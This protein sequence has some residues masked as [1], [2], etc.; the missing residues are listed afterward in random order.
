LNTLCSDIPKKLN[1]AIVYKN[2][3]ILR[4]FVGLWILE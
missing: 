4:N 2:S 3:E 1:N